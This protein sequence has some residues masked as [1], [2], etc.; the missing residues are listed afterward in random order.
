M[1]DVAVHHDRHARRSS[2]RGAPERRVTVVLPSCG[3]RRGDRDDARTVGPQRQSGAQGAKLL[4]ERRPRLARGIVLDAACRS[5]RGGRCAE[6]ARGTAGRVPCGHPRRCGTCCPPARAHR[7]AAA[8][9]AKPNAVAAAIHGPV[10]GKLGRP[11]ISAS[12]DLVRVRC[13]DRRL[14]RGLLDAL[15]HGLQQ[16]ARGV[17][18]A[19]HRVQRHL[20]L[21]SR[22]RSCACCVAQ[23]AAAVSPP[24]RGRR[25][26]RPRSRRP[27][28][29]S[30]R[31]RSDPRRQAAHGSPARPDDW[32]P[33]RPSIDCSCADSWSCRARSCTTDGAIAACAA[34][35]ARPL[36]ASSLPSASASALRAR[37]RFSVN[38]L[39][40]SL[41]SRACM[42]STSPF[43]AR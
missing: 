24:A 9:A 13:L 42:P 18:I 16:A 8:R 6:S 35:P 21:A 26:H 37:A 25:A 5:A 33:S 10:R 19:L 28:G 4:G 11:A 1:A 39:I 12:G 34:A 32:A 29:R 36:A 23:V 40:C 2:R 7:P 17:R 3:A 43:R 20:R 14:L 41:S 31:R 15:E 22:A 38:R 30:R 27:R